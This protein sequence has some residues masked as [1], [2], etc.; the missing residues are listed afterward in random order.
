MAI[1]VKH[2]EAEVKEGWVSILLL[3]A[4][5]LCL[6]WTLQAAQL[7][8]GIGVLQWIVL[9]GTLV[10][11]AL[12]RAHVPGLVAHGA[13]AI[14]GSGISVYLVSTLLPKGLGF[15]ARMLTM[16]LRI[17]DWFNQTMGGGESYDL[18][19]FVLFTALLFWLFTYIAAFAIFRTRFAWLAII[20][21][22]TV[23]LMNAY[24][25]PK[26]MPYFISYLLLS[27]LLI[28]R[29]TLFQQ[30]NEWRRERVRYSP[31][32][33]F[34]FLREGAF[35]AVL[36]IALAWFV[37]LATADY[38]DWPIWDVF[39]DPWE[40][41]QF[42]WNRAFASLSGSGPPR[43]SFFTN[44]LTLGGAVELAETPVMRV[45][46]PERAYWRALVFDEYTGQ[47][48]RNNDPEEIEIEPNAETPASMPYRDRGQ[49]VQTVQVYRTGEKVIFAANQVAS[50]NRLAIARLSYLPPEVVAETKAETLAIGPV[51]EISILAS[52]TPFRRSE[53]YEVT[54]WVSKAP[55][56][57]LR[58]AGDAYPGWVIK[59]Y[60]QLP[61]DL[62]ERV[63]LR[64]AEIAKP[65]SN[66]YDKAQAIER[67][68]R[69]IDYNETIEAPPPGVDAVDWFL[70][71]ST[72]G[73]CDYY[74]SAMAVML[75]AIGIPARVARGYASGEFDPASETYLVRELDAHAWPEVYFPGYG[76]IEFEP[77]ASEPLLARPADPEGEASEPNFSNIPPGI[78]AEEED[79]F[80][81]EKELME[82]GQ[83]PF[84]AWDIPWYERTDWL[85]NLVPVLP[86]VIG[87][88]L[89]WYIRRRQ[90]ASTTLV[91]IAFDNMLRYARWLRIDLGPHQTPYEC[92]EALKAVM[93]EGTENAQA[94]ADLYVKERYGGEGATVFDEMNA[95]DAWRRLRE[96]MWVYLLL[97]FLPI[98]AETA[99][100]LRAAVRSSA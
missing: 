3:L 84:T 51:A 23:I 7:A 100:S 15:W 42:H 53:T 85:V 67:F 62:P 91:T 29:F 39:E 93:E 44:T 20:P 19:M 27:L 40:E 57:A 12:A 68:L 50:V 65:Y 78:G 63:R 16:R 83:R 17:L 60:L 37:P 73:Y 49:L 75:R 64:A 56:S 70:F 79:P 47:G 36:V 43:F 10:G 1:Q 33:V 11:L 8:E 71:E 80:L 14:I 54:S 89:V 86:I 32:L 87:G 99:K 66:A 34:D 48:W 45:W 74:S 13:S 97:R 4:M 25:N 5:G 26:L 61:P 58:K 69:Q 21:N 96:V 30:E 18:L 55:P 28:V 41:I 77:T 95:M 22:G 24:Y 38:R 35:S 72:E 82:L 92:A 76:W 6:A 31:E 46:S 2:A 98:K 52:K 59:R 81:D 94:I 9:G 88:A 90:R